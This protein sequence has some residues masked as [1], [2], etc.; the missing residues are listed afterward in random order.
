MPQIWSGL[1]LDVDAEEA[2]FWG[3]SYP[4]AGMEEEDSKASETESSFIFHITIF[5]THPSIRPSSTNLIKRSVHSI[6]HCTSLLVHPSC[7]TF[8]KTFF[9]RRRLGC[10]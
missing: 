7:K 4:N 3:I 9:H 10:N 2:A 6:A 1:A 8:T 5:E